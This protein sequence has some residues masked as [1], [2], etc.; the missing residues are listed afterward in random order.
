M[1]LGKAAGP[2][3]VMADHL[4]AGQEVVIEQLTDICNCGGIK[5]SHCFPHTIY[6]VIQ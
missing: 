6:F 1:K 2:T 5:F 4:K 3:G